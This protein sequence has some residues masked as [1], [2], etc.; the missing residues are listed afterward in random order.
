MAHPLQRQPAQQKGA[1]RGSHSRTYPGALARPVLS[2]FP[3]AA[4][5]CASSRRALAHLPARPQAEVEPYL[6]GSLDTWRA[7]EGA[8]RRFLNTS[9]GPCRLLRGSEGEPPAAQGNK[10]PLS[11][12]GRRGSARQQ[13]VLLLARLQFGS[14]YTEGRERGRGWQEGGELGGEQAWLIV[15]LFLDAAVARPEKLWAHSDTLSVARLGSTRD[16]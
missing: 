9:R 14:G 7:P 11:E 8:A 4:I 1:R 12:P 2:S 16:I 13:L 5:R 10:R 15:V 3:S 6:R